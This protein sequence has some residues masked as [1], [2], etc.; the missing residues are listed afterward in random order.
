MWGSIWGV[1][2]T[3]FLKLQRN[4]SLQSC[5]SDPW[6]L[7]LGDLQ[8]LRGCLLQLQEQHERV[9]LEQGTWPH[10][11]RM[12]AEERHRAARAIPQALL[13][14]HPC[15]VAKT[16]QVSEVFYERPEQISCSSEFHSSIWK[17]LWE[18]HSWLTASSTQCDPGF[19]S[20][21]SF[22]CLSW[23]VSPFAFSQCHSVVLGKG[24]PTHFW[25]KMKS[26]V[27]VIQREN[28]NSHET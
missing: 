20:S 26:D 27:R 9:S 5:H 4:F 14:D 22:S 7:V 15:P 3:L 23:V 13:L 21:P 19:A 25:Y 10:T 18:A 11:I 8:R 24:W 1:M 2:I 17:L 6:S 12:Y 16:A 28:W